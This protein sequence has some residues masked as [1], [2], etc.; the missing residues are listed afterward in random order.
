MVSNEA[1]GLLLLESSWDR[2]MDIFTRS[3]GHV[4]IK[5]GTKKAANK[6]Q[7][8]PKYTPCGVVYSDKLKKLN[9]DTNYNKE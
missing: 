1:F 3:K 6:S 7:M 8:P 2:W 9:D 5:R 4:V